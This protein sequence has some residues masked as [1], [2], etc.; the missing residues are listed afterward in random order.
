MQAYQPRKSA[1]ARREATEVMGSSSAFPARDWTWSLAVRRRRG[2]AILLLALIAASVGL[3]CVHCYN[4]RSVPPQSVM[5]DEEGDVLAAFLQ[6]W[7]TSRSLGPE[8]HGREPVLAISRC[9]LLGPK[10]MPT[11]GPSTQEEL[12]WVWEELHREWPQLD[13]STWESLAAPRA[14]RGDLV[15]L[16]PPAVR[17]RVLLL[18]SADVYRVLG[19]GRDGW[20][21]VRRRWPGVEVLLELSRPGLSRSGLQALLY[22]QHRSGHEYGGGMF[23]LLTKKRGQWKVVESLDTWIS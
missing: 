9:T 14:A 23:M 17:A 16:L 2:A 15:V 4:V 22:V 18:S 10:A 13:R 12:Q 5:S 1:I 20:A 3:G 6:Y 21:E 11:Q 8:H 7:E 19:E